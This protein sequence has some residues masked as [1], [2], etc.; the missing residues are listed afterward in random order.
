[1][2][3]VLLSGGLLAHRD[4]GRREQSH[5]AS[6]G[7]LSHAISGLSHAIAVSAECME[8]LR[9]TRGAGGRV[10]GDVVR[11]AACAVGF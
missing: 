3:C 8:A 4:L 10:R 2:R 7:G 11:G 5:Q 6:S 9:G 1:M